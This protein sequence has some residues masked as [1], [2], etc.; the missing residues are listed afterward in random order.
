ME[1]KHVYVVLTKLTDGNV[2]ICCSRWNVMDAKEV[3]EDRKNRGMKAWY[4]VTTP[5]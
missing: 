5:E 2:A 3:V 4:V 1:K